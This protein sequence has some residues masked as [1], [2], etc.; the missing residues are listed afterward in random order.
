[1]V[2]G[3]SRYDVRGRSAFKTGSLPYDQRKVYSIGTKFLDYGRAI[4]RPVSA[5]S[6][7]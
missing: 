4:G 3:C 5:T 2:S 6:G 1:V 7:V